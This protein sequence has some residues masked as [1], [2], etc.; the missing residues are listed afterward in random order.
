[1]NPRKT[2]LF[3][4]L[5]LLCVAGCRHE[6]PPVAPVSTSGTGRT[7]D[8]YNAREG[9]NSDS[10]S[11]RELEGDARDARGDGRNRT[12][13]A[14]DPRRDALDPP[15]GRKCRVHLRR[16]AMGAASATPL[17]V[18]VDSPSGRAVQVTGTL[19]RISGD[20]LVIRGE[21]HTY[22]IPRNV[23]LAVDFDDAADAGVR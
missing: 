1:M 5:F 3:L 2:C 22:W 14:A 15:V 11:K 17:A 18:G 10:F 8:E 21:N 9:R 19:E 13:A 7:F 20:W 23:V 6:S 12:L 16:D 4:S